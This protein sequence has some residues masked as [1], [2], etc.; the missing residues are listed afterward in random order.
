MVRHLLVVLC[1]VA[2][3]VAI[4]VFHGHLWSSRKFLHFTNIVIFFD[5]IYFFSLV[6]LILIYYLIFYVI[7][8]VIEKFDLV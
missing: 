3:H 4:L 1:C 7:V 2:L 6:N 5:T 8:K